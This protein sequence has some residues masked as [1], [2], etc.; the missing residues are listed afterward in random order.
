MKEALGLIIAN[1][2]SQLGLTQEYIAFKMGITVNSYANIERGRV[3]VNIEKL[4]ILAN[5]LDV[6][7]HDII[8]QAE[9]I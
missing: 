2:R 7:V 5:V 1:Y 6:K 9:S 8:A 3:A 4:Y